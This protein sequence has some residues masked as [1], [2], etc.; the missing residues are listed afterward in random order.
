MNHSEEL[1]RTE[2]LVRNYTTENRTI[3]V[4]KG[5][6]LVINEGEMVAIMGKSG[7]GKTTLLKQFAMI[8]VPSEG[9][10][11]FKGKNTRKIRGEQL[12]RIRRREIGYVYQDYYLMDSLSVLENIMLPKILDHRKY[13]EC[14]EAAKQLADIMDVGDLLDKRTFELSGGEKQ[15]VAICRA[16]I[17]EPELILADEPTGNLDTGISEDVMHYL[18]VINKDLNKTIVLVTHDAYVASAGSRVVFLKDGLVDS[19][20]YSNGDRD[21]FFEDIV[22]QQKHIIKR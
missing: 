7:S 11:F 22:T 6:D 10:V 13:E 14:I 17:N 18:R 20:V 15:R 1:I 19:E 9:N 21:E 12:A 5:V 2:K 8:D 16:M 3:E 4:L